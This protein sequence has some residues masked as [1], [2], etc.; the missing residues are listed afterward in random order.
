MKHSISLIISGVDD[1][2]ETLRHI[3]AKHEFTL[4]CQM[5]Q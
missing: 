2:T 1:S 4:P 5:K 3:I